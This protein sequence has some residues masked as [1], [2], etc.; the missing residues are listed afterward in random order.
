MRTKGVGEDWRRIGEA[1]Y[2]ADLKFELD[3]SAWPRNIWPCR[4]KCVCCRI[5][6]HGR[7]GTLIVTALASAYMEYGSVPEAAG[8]LYGVKPVVIAVV[9]Q[10]LWRLGADS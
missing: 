8:L 10:A 1:Y 7:Y 3:V 9:L 5:L 2:H 4:G 6:E